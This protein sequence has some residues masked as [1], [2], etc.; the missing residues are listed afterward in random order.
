MTNKLRHYIIR[1][2][3]AFL[4]TTD[5][6]GALHNP[7]KG[8]PIIVEGQ[9]VGSSEAYY[10]ALRF[11]DAPDIQ[12]L[13]LAET[14][15]IQSKRK[16]YEFL[17]R[18]RADWFSVNIAVMRHSLRLKLSQHHDALSSLLCETGDRPIVE[19]SKRDPFWGAQPDSNGMAVG[20]NILGRLWMELR[21]ELQNDPAAYR[22]GVPAPRFP[23][24]TLLGREIGFTRPPEPAQMGLAL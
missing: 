9:S 14:K 17:D 4:Y 13:I 18:V 5:P 10:Q 20:E 11:P 16:A 3:A 8:F 23:N 24:A 2:S 7:C 22:E 19:I 15:P 1:E 6:F 12:R 21:L